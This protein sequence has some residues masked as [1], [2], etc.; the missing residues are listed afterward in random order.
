MPLFYE[1]DNDIFFKDFG[2][3]AILTKN[4]SK[5][6]V[7]MEVKNDHEIFNPMSLSGEDLSAFCKNID[8]QNLELKKMDI[9]DVE[10]VLYRITRVRKT[11]YGLGEIDLQ[12]E[13]D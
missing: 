2:Q 3:E 5:F 6:M 12:Y 1:K 9:I 10:G 8:I 11:N 7:V 13:E 4:G